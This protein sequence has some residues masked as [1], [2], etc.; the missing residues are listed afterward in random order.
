[1]DGKAEINEE[2]LCKLLDQANV[3]YDKNLLKV[4]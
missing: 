2:N 3:K 1:M 4:I